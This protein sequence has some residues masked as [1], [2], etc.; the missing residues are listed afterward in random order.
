MNFARLRSLMIKEF[1]SVWR[2]PKGRSALL[3]P[4]LVQLLIFSF[5]ATLDVKNIHIGIYNQ[6]MG[7]HSHEIIQRVRGS[8]YFTKLTHYTSQQEI[9]EAIDTQKVSVV[10]HIPADFSRKITRGEPAK[11]ALYLDGRRSN[12][13]VIVSGYVNKIVEGYTLGTLLKAPPKPIAQSTIVVRHW[14][15]KNLIDTWYTVSS[16]VGILAMIIALILT[17]LTVAREREMGTFDQLLVAPI[18]PIQILVGKVVPS[19]L[20]ALAEGTVILLCAIFIFQIPFQG[21]FL[22]VYASMVIFLLGVLGSGL[23]ISS[24]CQTQQQAVLGTFFFM[25]PSMLLS[26][27]ATPVANIVPWLR[28]F[29]ELIP[30]KHF[31]IVVK[32]VFLQ[33]MSAWDVWQNT[34][35][36]L[37]IGLATLAFATWFFQRRT[38]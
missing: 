16:L 9:Q 11:L 22:L 38:Q 13:A 31:L 17:S 37:I 25:T 4:P 28:P 6:D 1:L 34:W 12:A 29:A 23:F 21:S 24:L 35:P 30:L 19:L 27:F 32:G 18:T 10:M 5:A 15:N 14:F 3:A 8:S 7:I 20:L 2:D 26:G 36:N 33:N